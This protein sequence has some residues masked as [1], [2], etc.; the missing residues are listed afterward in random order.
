M[1]TITS[2]NTKVFKNTA[3]NSNG[4][5]R[6]WFNYSI[7]TK[8]TD[9]NYDY[10]SKQ[11]K[12]KKGEEPKETCNI[13]INSAF[14]SFYKK[15]EDIYLACYCPP[16]PCHGDIITQKLQKRLLKEKIMEAKKVREKNEM[17]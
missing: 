5:E 11:I 1:L 9:N 10:M 8:L 16:E 3:M 12:F 6:V 7:A 2:D 14:Q 15:G 13:K 4:E 17:G